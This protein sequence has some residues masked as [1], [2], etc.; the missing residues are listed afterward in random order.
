MIVYLQKK[1]IDTTK[2]NSI[3]LTLSLTNTKQT[4]NILSLAT[5]AAVTVVSWLIV[6]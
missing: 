4:F 1:K 2:F 5:N 3:D 6:S